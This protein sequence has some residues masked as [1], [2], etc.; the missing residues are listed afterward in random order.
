MKRLPFIDSDCT[1]FEQYDQM[2]MRTVLHVAS[3][4][5]EKIV[6]DLLAEMGKALCGTIETMNKELSWLDSARSYSPGSDT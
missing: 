6:G 2:E 1:T 5:N 4:A 3:R